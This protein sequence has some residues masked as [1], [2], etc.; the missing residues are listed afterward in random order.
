MKFDVIVPPKQKESLL[1]INSNSLKKRRKL[2]N[3]LPSSGVIRCSTSL[4]FNF[5]V[6]PNKK[7]SLHKP[8]NKPKYK[9]LLN[10]K[11]FKAV[12]CKLSLVGDSV[13]T[14]PTAWITVR[15]V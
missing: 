9:F 3:P 4:K 7:E 8:S 15:E 5:I 12:G 11:N 1:K 6:P 2:H 14:G 10:Q 13:Q